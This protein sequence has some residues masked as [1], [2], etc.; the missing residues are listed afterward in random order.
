ML[1]ACIFNQLIVQILYKVK[2]LQNNNNNYS[3]N[4]YEIP[5]INDINTQESTGKQKS[6]NGNP[7]N[8]ILSIYDLNPDSNPVTFYV[9]FT[10]LFEPSMINKFSVVFFSDIVK[11]TYREND[12][13]YTQLNDT[14]ISFSII[15]PITSYYN[16]TFC[17]KNKIFKTLFHNIS[18]VDMVPSDVSSLEC[19]GRYDHRWCRAKHICWQNK[20]FIFF[21][22]REAKINR[23]SMIPGSRPIPHDYPK[24]RVVVQYKMFESKYPLPS[25]ILKSII[26]E[27]SF[28]T[29]RW[30]SMEYLW[31]ALFDYTLPLFWT[32][33]LN[34]GSNSTNDR[35]FTID[36]N[37]SKKGYQFLGPFTNHTIENIKI[38]LTKYNNTCFDDAIIGFPKSEYDI[39]YEKWN[40]SPLLLPYEYPLE[41]FKGFREK[42]ISYYSVPEKVKKSA[43][44]S[45]DD[46]MKDRCEPDPNHPR[47]VIA[48]RNSTMRD[49][50]NQDEFTNN[51]KKI[52][53]NCIVDPYVYG[54]ES[55]GEQMIRYCNASI[56]L[57][58][59]GSQLSHMVWMKI[60]DKNKP[61]AV[62]EIKPYKYTCRDWY[63]QIADG[64]GI[65]YYQWTN[66]FL[67]NTKTGREKSNG[68]SMNKYNK[69]IKGELS[70]LDCHDYLRDQ[71]TVVD[72]KSFASTL[73]KALKYVTKV[74]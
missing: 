66:P 51:V 6:D 54:G 9:K 3:I 64:A 10:K 57:S 44:F 30:Y 67:Y 43:N 12:F 71:P 25:N 14:F 48:Y 52:C 72:F 13:N 27:R 70:C 21:G 1:S 19:F 56:L 22:L 8:N 17:W 58:I 26:K 41:A 4:R 29:C 16:V 60:D 47:I 69:C 61:T 63:K 28:L 40:D 73:K 20:R 31:H 59:H 36:E 11:F 5:E 15:I 2:I 68:F 23:T 74:K 50:V 46:F 39:N 18:K 7:D 49:I 62:I 37:T 33:K 34:G 53:P 42:M 65:K 45:I 32:T 35:I 24:C 55:F 38:N